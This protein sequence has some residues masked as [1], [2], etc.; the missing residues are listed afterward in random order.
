MSYR[1]LRTLAKNEG[2]ILRD[3]MV[4]LSQGM[5]V[6][7]VEAWVEVDGEE[8]LMVFITNNPT[9]SPRSVC[10]LHRR[11]WDIEVFF[12]QVKQTL[13]LGS[14]LGHSANAVRWQV[15]SA[16][17]VYVLLRFEAHLINLGHSF[18]R[19]FAVVRAALWER[20]DLRALLTGYR[21]AGGSF[22]ILGALQ[23]AWL[24]GFA[25]GYP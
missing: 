13:K 23:Q 3:Q 6:R 4:R 8:R 12:K 24:P 21:T 1:V 7:R 14:F 22:R 17:L 20:V 16:L 19:L 18:T 5:V 2:E 15:F 9:W 10:D 25:R 11:R